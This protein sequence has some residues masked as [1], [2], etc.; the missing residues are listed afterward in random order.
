[1]SI[2]PLSKTRIALALLLLATAT[3]PAL[4]QQDNFRETRIHH[5]AAGSWSGPRLHDGQPDVQ[6]HWSNTIGNHNDFT[7][8]DKQPSRV[9][10]TSDGEVP[11]QPWARAKAEEFAAHLENPIRPEYVEPFARCAPGGPSKSL[12]WHGFEIRQYPGYV[13]FLFDSG[14][15]L[16]HLDDKPHLPES[17]SLWNGDSR[18]RWDGNTL[19]VTVGNHN[20][21][22]RFGRSGEFVSPAAS[23]EERFHFESDGGYFLYE[24]TY[25]DPEVLTEPM[26]ISIPVKRITP[27]T[28]PDG[29]N[30]IT[31]PVQFADAAR[32]RD[33]EVWERT[34][35]ENNADHGQVA[36]EE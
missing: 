28:E 5:V 7:S 14:T 24:A 16:V 21:K 12:L 11:F 32:G 2:K 17:V 22:A 26:T 3:T 20:A 36:I 10:S 35:V 25:T 18:G 27:E 4:A 8:T 19:H 31:F 33:I 15:R 30:N 34:C 6:G 29:W 13:L 23:I 1:M 9:T